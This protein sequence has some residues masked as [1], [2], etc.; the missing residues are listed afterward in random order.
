MKK[1]LFQLMSMLMVAVLS[2][3]FASCGSDDEENDGGLIGIWVEADDKPEL[4]LIFQESGVG[5]F[6]RLQYKKK[7]TPLQ[8][9][10]EWNGSFTYV[11]TDEKTGSI[12]APRYF[13]DSYLPETETFNYVISDKTMNLYDSKHPDDLEYVLKKQ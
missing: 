9:E 3:G 13:D 8:V 7:T 12:T 1:Y 5:T 11:S 6:V 10:Q 2:T 4:K